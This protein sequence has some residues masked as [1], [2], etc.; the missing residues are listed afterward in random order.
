MPGQRYVVIVVV[1]RIHSINSRFGYAVGDLV[2]KLV[3][4]QLRQN[5]SVADRLFRWSGPAFI[6]L[7]ERV[8][9]IEAVRMEIGRITS[10]NL[11]RFFEIGGRPVLLPVSAS[12]LVVQLTPPSVEMIAA[13]EKFVASHMET[14][15]QLYAASASK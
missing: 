13:I 4:E 10:K 11:Q 5:L 12:W 8:E 2:L 3:L 7:L 1:D 15:N 14:T 6:A 9:S